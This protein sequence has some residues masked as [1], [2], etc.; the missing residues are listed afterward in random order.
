[1][2]AGSA[3]SEC[4]DGC[5]LSNGGCCVTTSVTPSEEAAAADAAAADAASIGRYLLVFKSKD[6]Q[7]HE[8]S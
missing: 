1:M 7:K 4:R 2:A 8:V 6:Q 5:W 3:G